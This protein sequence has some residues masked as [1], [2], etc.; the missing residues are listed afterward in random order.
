[1]TFA[2]A[3]MVDVSPYIL[4]DAAFQLSFL[5]MAGL[6]FL[7]PVFRSLG[8]R[9]IEAALGEEGIM[10]Q[11]ANFASSSLGAT[12]AAIIAVWPLVA[13]YF[14]V[15]SFVGPLATF[16]ALPALPGV[17]LAGILTGILGLFALPVAH[18]AGWLAWLFLTYII[19]LLGRL[20]AL[21]LSFIEV[22]EVNV[23]FIAIYYSVLAAA[24]GS[25]ATAESWAD[26]CPNPPGH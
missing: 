23:S 22:G 24:Y 11:V 10:T 3:I 7:F 17:I 2:A 8:E 4:G 1:M 14:G 16:L 26:C 9:M 15:V 5:A 6:V 12:L 21:P 13:Y 18:V 19:L 20:S 25:T